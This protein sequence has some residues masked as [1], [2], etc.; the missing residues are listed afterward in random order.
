MKKIVSNLMKLSALTMI[1]ALIVPV[2]TH[3]QGGKANFSGTW[4]LNAEK[5]TQPQGGGGGGGGGQRMGGGNFVI[6]QEANL[7]TRTSTG[8]DGTQRVTK[9]TLDGKESVNTSRGGDSK[10]VATWSADGK[11]L[12]IVTTRTTDNGERKS[13]EAWTLT[14]AKTLSILSTSP[15]RDGGAE[16]KSTRVYDKK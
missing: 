10:S 3:A 4:A 9:Y 5:S 14:D 6:T 2:I 7:L 15:G 13:T 1:L 8:Q 16:R 11:T 12:T